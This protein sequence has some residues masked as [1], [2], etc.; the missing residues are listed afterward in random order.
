[1]IFNYISHTASLLKINVQHMH[2]D[3]AHRVETAVTTRHREHLKN[4]SLVEIPLSK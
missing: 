2:S 1:M 3:V 4:I